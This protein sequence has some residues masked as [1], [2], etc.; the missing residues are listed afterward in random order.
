[1]VWWSRPVC[2]SPVVA[3]Y[4]G[5]LD[6]GHAISNLW[7]LIAGREEVPYSMLLASWWLQIDDSWLGKLI[8]RRPAG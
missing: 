5:R 1:M 2:G 4:G 7:S 6:G 8:R 3:L